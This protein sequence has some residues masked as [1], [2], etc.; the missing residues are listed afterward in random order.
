L[1]KSYGQPAVSCQIFK[2][3]PLEIG[4]HPVLS[5][6]LKA[7]ANFSP[8]LGSDN[9][10]LKQARYLVATLKE[11]RW[12]SNFSDLTQ[13]LQSC[14]PGLQ[15]QPWTGFSERFQHY[16]SVRIARGF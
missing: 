5:F 15:G 14:F 6:T 7:F 3:K 10:G 11:L 12:G 8:G 1:E 4:V 16:S 2:G 13:L 9:P